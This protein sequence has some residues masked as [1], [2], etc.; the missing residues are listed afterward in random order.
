[1]Y[2][3]LGKRL[4]ELGFVAVIVGYPTYP[5]SD[6]VIQ[7]NTVNKVLE[8]VF[9]AISKYGGDEEAIFLSGHSSGAHIGALHLIQAASS[10]QTT[11]IKGFVGF[12]GVYDIGEHYKFEAGRG[13]EEVS[14]MKPAAGGIDHF[15]EHSPTLLVP[16]LD[17]EAIRRMPPMLLLHGDADATVPL[18]S[19]ECF[20][21]ALKAAGAVAS[22]EVL[23]ATDHM[24]FLAFTMLG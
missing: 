15:D 14:P 21:Q 2:S 18:S 10:G 11:R 7:A 1:M 4:R 24:D 13:V 6:M 5:D 20:H 19:A 9:R 17:E 3:L 16:A 22:L 23:P 8:W 12:S